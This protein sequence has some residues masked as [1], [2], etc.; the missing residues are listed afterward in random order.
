MKVAIGC[1]HGGIN[2]KPL[3]IQYLK[4]NQI[5]FE[6]FG[7]FD[8]KSTDYNEYALAVSKAVAS[9]EFDRGILFWYISWQIKENF[10]FFTSKYK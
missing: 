4:E 6:D 9:G 7:C 1:D 2:L 5:E 3:L 8:N 10:P